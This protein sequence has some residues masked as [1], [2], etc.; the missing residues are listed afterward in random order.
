MK[1]VPMPPS[2]RPQVPLSTASQPT[3][4]TSAFL[5]QN[6]LQY[7]M[8]QRAGGLSAQDLSFFEGL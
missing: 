6:G 4:D 2:L 3:A 8:G 7:R 5:M 1:A